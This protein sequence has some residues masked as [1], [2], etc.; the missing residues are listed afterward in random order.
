MQLFPSDRE[1]WI[2]LWQDARENSPMRRRRCRIVDEVIE[3]WNRRAQCYAQRTSEQNARERQKMVIAMLE[4]EGALRPGFSVLD[5]GA[6]PGNYTIPFARLCRQ[7][8]AV[9]PAAEMVRILKDKVAAEQLENVRIIQRTW[10]EVRVEEEGMT[11]QFDLVFAS[12][13]P[14]VQDP[15]TLEKMIKASRGYCYLSA[16][17]GQRWGRAHRDLWQRF[18]NEDMGG[19]PGDILYPFGLLYAMGYRPNLRFV[20]NRR[21]R[22]HR[23]EKAIEELT[24]FF[25]NY[26][27]I[28]P[29]VRQVIEEYVREHARDGVFQQETGG[30]WGMMLWRVNDVVAG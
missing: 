20:A 8:T 6:G 21:M 27:D 16:F 29:E 19:N 12:M 3:N 28:T 4:K 5:I 18:F 24:R 10:Q 2:K 26:M 15:E 9:E 14:G 22:E 17:S 30:C 23:M 1:I 7:V 25:W 13:T 11:G